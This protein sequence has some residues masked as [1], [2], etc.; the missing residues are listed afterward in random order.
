MNELI[1][2]LKERKYLINISQLEREC[3]MPN[4]SIHNCIKNKGCKHFRKNSEIIK[5][6]LFKYGIVI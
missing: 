2:K 6:V 4:Y 3:L 1:E 5:N